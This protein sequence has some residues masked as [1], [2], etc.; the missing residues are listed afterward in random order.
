M[1][2]V[3]EKYG[4][5]L[6]GEYS[7]MG[8]KQRRRESYSGNDFESQERSS[9]YSAERSSAPECSAYDS[10][11]KWLNEWTEKNRETEKQYYTKIDRVEK[12]EK[13]ESLQLSRSGGG[14]MRFPKVCARRP[15]RVPLRT[16][17]PVPTAVTIRSASP[18]KACRENRVS[19]PPT[20]DRN[21][22][23]PGR[24]AETG[25]LRSSSTRPW[26]RE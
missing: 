1:K 2:I 7:G 3:S 4:G 21:G 16:F 19:R 5:G 25:F 24:S 9:E 11:Q 22:D 12:K 26:G 20:R 8:N 17:P 13:L 14:T 18:P 23:P 6:R 10:A 15:G